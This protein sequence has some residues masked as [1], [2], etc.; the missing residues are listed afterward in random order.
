[1]GR[2]FNVGVERDAEGYSVA[3]VSTLQGCHTQARPL[4]EVMDRIKETIEGDFWR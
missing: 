2:E 3:S 1:M 4:D